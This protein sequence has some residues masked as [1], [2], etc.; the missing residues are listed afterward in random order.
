MARKKAAVPRKAEP[1]FKRLFYAS[2]AVIIFLL[3]IL[4]VV[5]SYVLQASV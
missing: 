3:I 1:N 4:A 2:V 5:V